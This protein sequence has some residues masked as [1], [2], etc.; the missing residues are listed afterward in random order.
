MVC[1]TIYFP[2]NFAI[3]QNEAQFSLH[4]G[5]YQQT[6]APGINHQRSQDLGTISQI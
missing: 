1:L 4:F 3:K 2:D 6:V 5:E